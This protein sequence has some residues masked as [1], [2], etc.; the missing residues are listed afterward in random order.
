MTRSHVWPVDRMLPDT[1][2]L[3]ER[4]RGRAVDHRAGRVIGNFGDR[5][6]AL[7][8]IDGFLRERAFGQLLREHQRKAL[9][10][11]DLWLYVCD[12]VPDQ[13]PSTRPRSWISAAGT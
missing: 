7:S 11:R 1:I 5:V 9:V 2:L 10:E 3:A 12:P 8:N 6:T 13:R 4:G